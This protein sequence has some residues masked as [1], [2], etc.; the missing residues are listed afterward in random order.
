V[1]FSKSSFLDPWDPFCPKNLVHPR[2]FK[3]GAII[4]KFGTLM[5][6][7]NTWGIF[8]FSFFENFYFWVLGT[9]FILKLCGSVENLVYY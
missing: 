1:I 4:L 8:S 6:E 9:L 7:M 5:D 3:N 2:E